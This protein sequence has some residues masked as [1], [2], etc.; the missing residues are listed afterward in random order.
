MLDRET[1]RRHRLYQM[2]YNYA[3]PGYA[4][5]VGTPPTFEGGLPPGVY[6]LIYSRGVSDELVYVTD[7]HDPVPMGYRVVNRCVAVP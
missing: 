6:D 4:L 5:S 7:R 1:G 2:T 3:S